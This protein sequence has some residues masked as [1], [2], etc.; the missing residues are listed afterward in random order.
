MTSTTSARLGFLQ[1]LLTVLRDS[2]HAGLLV[3][4]DEVETLQRVRSDVRE[5]ALNALRQLHRRGRRRPVPRPVPGDHRHAGVLRRAAGRAAAA[6]LAQRLAHRLHGDPRF[7]N[8]RAV[9]IRLPGFDLRPAGRS[10]AARSATCTSPALPTRAGSR[11]VVDD[12]YVGGPGPGGDRRARRPGR[13]RAA[14]LPEQAGRAVLDRV[15][16]FPDFD[17]RAHYALTLSGSE[18]TDVERN[19]WRSRQPIADDVDLDL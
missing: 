16:Q 8:P 2:G 11:S 19:A 1:G 5:K 6:P 15:D 17:P 9:Q 13:R 4:L 3:V 12:A 14:D 10:S 7:D 18:L